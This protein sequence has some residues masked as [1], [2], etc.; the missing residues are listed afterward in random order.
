[1]KRLG[2]CLIVLLTLISCRHRHETDLVLSKAP[3]S[4]SN[5]CDS[6]TLSNPKDKINVC[7]S[8]YIE[9]FSNLYIIK[10]KKSLNLAGKA[11]ELAQ[12][13]GVIAGEYSKAPHLVVEDLHPSV[14]KTKEFDLPHSQKVPPPPTTPPPPPP[15]LVPIAS[16]VKSIQAS[17]FFGKDVPGDI[18]VHEVD[19]INGL[20][21]NDWGNPEHI[22]F[23][24]GSMLNNFPQIQ[25]LKQGY[26]P[27]ILEMG[28][29][30]FTLYG[31]H[32]GSIFASVTKDLPSQASS[33]HFLIPDFIPKASL[34]GG[35]NVG[36][37]YRGTW[38][39]K[40][41]VGKSVDANEFYAFNTFHQ[42]PVSF[43][44]PIY[45]GRP[46][47]NG[48]A[49]VMEMAKG[50]ASKVVSR[51]D[52]NFESFATELSQRVAEM[53]SIGWVHGD[54]KLENFLELGN[55][56]LVLSDFEVSTQAGSYNVIAADAKYMD[57]WRYKYGQMNYPS[58]IYT[59]G[60]VLGEIFLKRKKISLTQPD[61][62]L[63]E[64]WKKTGDNSLSN[65]YY[66]QAGQFQEDVKSALA[67]DTSEEAKL[68]RRML[69]EPVDATYP[70]MY[71]ISERFRTRNF[72]GELSQAH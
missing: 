59:M 10:A 67:A 57:P 22:L 33:M 1:M 11:G 28:A 8:G 26:S 14:P 36:A 43:Y 60:I 68:L 65:Q 45:E 2:L 24:E 55:G 23:Q 38:N 17:Q 42:Y 54:L 47:M 25:Y 29:Y 12:E 19:S 35:V 20:P 44:V 6:I 64:K 61:F 49:V 4:S 37:V 9:P 30:Q 72:T 46:F 39:G 56:R 21:F 40:E 15:P 5:E 27:Q 34:T 70:H 66:Q 16:Q 52:F 71:E 18:S 13:A 51:S 31:F 48:G 50:D 32:N 3:V 7:S 63:L 58:D 53:H 62:S 69:D 41:V